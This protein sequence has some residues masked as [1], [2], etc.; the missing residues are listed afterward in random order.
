MMSDFGLPILLGAVILVIIV[1]S[2]WLALTLSKRGCPPTAA[3]ESSPRRTAKE[4]RTLLRLYRD[5]HGLWVVEV[6]G[7]PYR[8][9]TEV[10]DAAL[11]DE[12]VESVR[13]LAAFVKPE[14]TRRQE[15]RAEQAQSAPPE[16]R[17][18]A[19]AAPSSLKPTLSLVYGDREDR[20]LRRPAMR[21]AQPPVLLPTIDLAHEI[22]EIVEAMQA[23]HPAL[24]DR[25]I[26]LQ[27]GV[28]GGVLFVVDGVIYEAVE[29]IPD[30][31]VRALIRAATRAWEERID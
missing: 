30:G 29:A 10:E 27:N 5:E 7:R 1:L 13:F 31:E 28:D 4:P 2:A 3:E 26:R 18:P 21:P 20:R 6:K 9:L 22:G 12:V 25:R 8:D 15:G 23:D 17:K 11:R 16:E 19:A 24:K 14:L